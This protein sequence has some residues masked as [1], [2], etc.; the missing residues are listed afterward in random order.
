MQPNKESINLAILLTKFS[1][2]TAV[3]FTPPGNFYVAY[4]YDES[5]GDFSA[6]WQTSNLSHALDKADPDILE[7]S[8]VR[9]SR[10]DLAQALEEQGI[11]PSEENIDE[12]AESV[13]NMEGWR[14]TAIS[15]GNE[16]LSNE[17]WQMAN[18][19]QHND[20]R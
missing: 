16:Y 17:A 5:T 6:L 2:N 11:D 10:W 1:N 7:D 3:F 15:E 8:V 12:L 20:K 19:E 4:D 9:W 14:A 18:L 13:L